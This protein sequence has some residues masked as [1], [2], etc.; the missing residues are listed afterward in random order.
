MQ[1]LTYASTRPTNVKLPQRNK[2]VCRFVTN[3]Q[4]TLISSRHT[5]SGT[6][7]LSERAVHRINI[8]QSA[9]QRRRI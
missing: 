2:P 5:Q 4:G 3:Q 9:T 6:N 7:P 1:V 8:S